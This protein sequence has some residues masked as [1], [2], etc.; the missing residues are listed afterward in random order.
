[1]P[2]TFGGMSRADINDFANGVLLDFLDAFHESLK[3]DLVE[4]F[5]DRWL[6]EGVKR[7]LQADYF[8][9]ARKMLESPMR[10]ID[11]GKTDEELFGVEHLA[12][13]VLGNWKPLFVTK[14]ED[15]NRT[16]V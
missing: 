15:R 16:Q 10:T 11:M 2:V 1:M 13:V 3:A 8:D 6:D 7:H 9:R 4:S 12:S 14:F 5:G